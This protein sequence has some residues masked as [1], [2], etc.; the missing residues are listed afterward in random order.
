MNLS[1]P[2]QS[3]LSIAQFIERT[4]L[5]NPY[6]PL[7]PTFKQ[8]LF[9]GDQREE[10]FY[11]GA[12][13]GAKSYAALMGALQFVDKPK[14]NAL[15]LRSTF[16]ELS[17][18]E[19]L[20]SVSHEWLGPTDAVWSERAHRW[21]FPSGATLG[22]GYVE[23]NKDVHQYQGASYQYICFDELAN[24]TEFRYTYMF[25]RL[26][27]A[28][29]DTETFPLRMRGTGN[30]DGIGY[31]WCKRRFVD[32]STREPGIGFIPSLLTDNPYLD[33]EAYIRSLSKLDPIT[34]ERLLKGDWT[35]RPEGTLFKRHW[36]PIIDEDQVP[37]GLRETRYWDLA[38]TAPS[39]A[40]AD[41]DYTAGARLGYKDGR[42]YIFDIRAI[43]DTPF[44]VEKLIKQTSA[45]DGRSVEVGMEE[46]GGA[47]GKNTTAY[48]R[49]K[50]LPGFAFYTERP[51][52]S[53]AERARII[54]SM[55]QAGNVLLVA[56][57]KGDN[58]WMKE[59]L[60]EIELFPIGAHDD[61]LDAVAGA[62]RRLTDADEISLPY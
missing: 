29:D 3:A 50:V 11:G 53:K 38:A 18:P 57:K 49:R 52:G 27:R 34:R 4:V 13:G 26:R 31:E 45:L 48:Y 33:Q 17:Q 2:V 54:A 6:I 24:H 62:Q 21:T 23:T 58:G 8:M 42:L 14:Y 55:A 60:D 9:L 5:N 25:S 39:E 32:D 7:A 16:T 20:I 37:A 51:T 12:A 10:L 36:F 46:E 28:K 19:A 22:F 15:I 56:S 61:R 44:E 40:N 47:S 59:F 43:Q 1:G 35:V 41:P 30:P